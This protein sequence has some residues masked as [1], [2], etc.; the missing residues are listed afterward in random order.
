[1]VDILLLLPLMSVLGL[2]SEMAEGIPSSVYDRGVESAILLHE[3][4]RCC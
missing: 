1:M 2:V 4:H 3:D